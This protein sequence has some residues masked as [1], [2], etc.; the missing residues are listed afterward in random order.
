MGIEW[1]LGRL[2]HRVAAKWGLA[3]ECYRNAAV[4]YLFGREDMFDE[5]NKSFES[6]SRKL[7]ARSLNYCADFKLL[8]CQL[9]AG[10]S[11][12]TVVR[13][14]LGDEAQIGGSSSATKE[15]VIETLNS[16]LRFKGDEGAHPNL[17]YLESSQSQEDFD[18]VVSSVHKILA[19]SDLIVSFWLKSGHPFYPVFWDFAF[20]IEMADDSILFI[21]SSSD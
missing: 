4:E 6:I 16:A 7:F 2:S 1:R 12:D 11:L 20:W 3:L 5:I 18:S 8:R 17:D 9:K 13:S 14:A 15:E 10:E 19:D 21:A